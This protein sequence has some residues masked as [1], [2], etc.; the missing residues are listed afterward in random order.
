MAAGHASD[1]GGIATPHHLI[2][3]DMI[4]K[5]IR[6]SADGAKATV[7]PQSRPNFY[8]DTK[9]TFE[10]YHYWANQSREL[11]NSIKTKRGWLFGFFGRK[12]KKSSEELNSIP[13]QG[14]L[15]KSSEKPHDAVVPDNA[16]AITESEWNNAR[17]AMRTATWGE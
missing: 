11:E 14:A 6:A 3:T 10:E 9:I 13:T 15:E 16:S 4:T 5:G 7:P 1:A 12:N 8:N 17:G 2:E